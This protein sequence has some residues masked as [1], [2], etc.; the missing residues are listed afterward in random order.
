MNT[1]LGFEEQN[2]SEHIKNNQATSSDLVLNVKGDVI[3][4]YAIFLT[5]PISM[6]Q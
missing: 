2:S 6:L 3:D 4:F 5:T 1:K